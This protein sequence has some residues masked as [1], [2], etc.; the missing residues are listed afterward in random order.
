M[1]IRNSWTNFFKSNHTFYHLEAVQCRPIFFFHQ[2]TKF[3]NSKMTDTER[4]TH[5]VEIGARKSSPHLTLVCN[6]HKRNEWMNFNWESEFRTRIENQNLE[7][8]SGIRIWRFGHV[9]LCKE[10]SRN[11][12]QDVADRL[13]LEARE[14]SLSSSS[15]SSH[16]IVLYYILRNW[17][18]LSRGYFLLLKIK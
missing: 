16:C 11:F 5:T 17:S 6:L 8:E 14:N 2:K 4:H 1:K 9:G 10:S 7:S 18:R 3:A 15:S 13:V 12:D